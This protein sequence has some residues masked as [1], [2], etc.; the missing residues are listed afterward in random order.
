MAEDGSHVV[1]TDHSDSSRQD[2]AS[3]GGPNN[4]DVDMDVFPTNSS[5]CSKPNHTKN[6]LALSVGFV[7][8]FTSFRALQNLQVRSFSGGYYFFRLLAYF[9]GYNFFRLLA[10]FLQ[11]TIFS[12]YNSQFFRVAIFSLQIT[13]Y[14]RYYLCQVSATYGI[15]FFKFIVIIVMFIIQGLLV[16]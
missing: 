7:L 15:L 13:N 3:H 11:A 14:L 5:C 16:R 2:T 8:V 6:L 1:A 4:V 9:S 10:Y 12:A